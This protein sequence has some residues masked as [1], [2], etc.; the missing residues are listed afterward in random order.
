M[1][2]LYQTKKNNIC[3]NSSMCILAPNCGWTCV[4]SSVKGV[5]K[6]DFVQYWTRQCSNAPASWCF[7]IFCLFFLSNLYCF[8]RW[9]WMLVTYS[10]WSL[11]VNV[12]YG[13][14]I[15]SGPWMWMLF[16][17]SFWSL[18]VNVSYLFFLVLECEC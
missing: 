3:R 15:L 12:V 5:I 8:S 4:Q 2:Y 14:N 6:I 13:I 11:N 17:Y 10:F 18:N 16:I 1:W 9:W 7:I